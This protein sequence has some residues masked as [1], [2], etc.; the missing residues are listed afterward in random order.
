[1]VYTIRGRHS[2]FCIGRAQ[3]IHCAMMQHMTAVGHCHVRPTPTNTKYLP[4][5]GNVDYRVGPV[6]QKWFSCQM[7]QPLK[8]DV[9]YRLGCLSVTVCTC[10]K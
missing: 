7:N 2:H 6:T 8:E 9:S 3:S 1:M 10:S 5:E 4:I